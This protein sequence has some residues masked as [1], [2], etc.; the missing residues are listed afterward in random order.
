[1]KAQVSRLPA[2]P[3]DRSP[4]DDRY[5]MVLLAQGRM[6]TDADWNEQVTTARSLTVEGLD[7]T[8][9]SGVPRQGGVLAALQADGKGT[10]A[11][12]D[13]FV[14]GIRASVRPVDEAAA[15]AFSFGSQ[16]D[17]LAASG[18]SL[19]V[20]EAV[21][22]DVWDRTVTS[23]EDGSLA[24]PAW[25]GA[26]TS[27][28]TR[29]MAQLKQCAVAAGVPLAADPLANPAIGNGRIAA[30]L[31]DSVETPDP[32][33][34]CA[35]ELS[36]PAKV[37]N[38]LFRLE[39]H[40]VDNPADPTS[41]TLKWS[42][43]NGAEHHRFVPAPPGWFID[44]DHHYEYFDTR[45]EQ[46]MGVFLSKP[47]GS[48]LGAVPLVKGTDAAPT[49]PGAGSWVG[50]RRWDG[51]CTLAKGAGGWALVTGLER[52][53][54]LV[55]GGNPATI[56]AGVLTL[57]LTSLEV[58]LRL[59]GPGNA[60]LQALRGDHWAVEVRGG[61]PAPAAGQADP[62]CRIESETPVGIHH[63]YLVLGTWTASGTLEVGSDAARRA[64]S[65]PPLSD[66][67]ADDVGFVPQCA[68]G[69][70]PPTA[71]T[72]KRALDALCDLDAG[73]VAFTSDGCETLS[74]S[75]NV[76]EALDALCAALG[77][78]VDDC[79]HR[80]ALFGRGVVCGLVPS[81]T[82]R[83]DPRR[84]VLDATVD[85][86]RRQPDAVVVSEDD[87]REGRV[88]PPSRTRVELI[89][90]L[91]AAGDDFGTRE[92]MRAIREVEPA[93]RGDALDDRLSHVIDALDVPRPGRRESV[94]VR[95]RTE[96]GTVVDGKGCFHEVPELDLTEVLPAWRIVLGV[97][98]QSARV[99]VTRLRALASGRDL[100]S[101]L[102]DETW[103]HDL[104]GR[105]DELA[106]TVIGAGATS[107][108]QVRD[109]LAELAWT[110]VTLRD[111]V[112]EVAIDVL[113]NRR[114]PTATTGWLYLAF[115]EVGRPALHFRREAP[116]PWLHTPSMLMPAEPVVAAPHHDLTAIIGTVI[117]RV[118]SETRF[119]GPRPDPAT[120]LTASLDDHGRLPL[121]AITT[122]HILAG[123]DDDTHAIDRAA[124]DSAVGALLSGGATDVALPDLTVLNS[125]LGPLRLGHRFELPDASLP[126]I[127]TLPGVIVAGDDGSS[128]EDLV[129]GTWFGY[130]DLACPQANDGAVCLGK[131]VVYGSKAVVVPDDREQIITTPANLNAVHVATHR[132]PVYDQ[133]LA[134]IKEVEG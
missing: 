102:V 122:S 91:R 76:Q 22:L 62:R 92:V 39:V 83:T 104:G 19:T 103:E 67:R 124:V 114:E 118:I 7:D 16:A 68:N 133:V 55:G 21:Y 15:A 111:A 134:R 50:V 10:L 109:K 100:D 94:P 64:H 119:E 81:A 5:D 56:A 66:L 34:P 1:M 132:A 80:L 49:H 121:N 96:P 54:D 63:H 59:S 28:R 18:A 77:K 70:F 98:P 45:S 40:D 130:R 74:A 125:P 95:F 14:D 58:K 12:G 33:D 75:R 48:S 61:L 4:T 88:P 25:H 51:W 13:A 120:I 6:V 3:T 101:E 90:R 93:L 24:D 38:Y 9:A 127:N 43:E 72:V 52:G 99:L 11:W 31:R 17:L 36:L 44:G 108:R 115:D 106:E 41:L 60:G 131:V 30:T 29:T 69:L 89:R 79:R 57:P 78:R 37:G 26:D 107:D 112:A 73:H 126:I 46:N 85:L 47:A 84:A 35:N 20:G 2:A 128:V 65:F 110:S 113:S 123:F 116:A 71:V 105:I 53:V 42:V 129:E 82:I 97:Q 23:I 32:C 117:D 86:V 27:F 87:E 8:V